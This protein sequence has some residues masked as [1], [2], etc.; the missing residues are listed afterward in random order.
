MSKFQVPSS[1]VV[2]CGNGRKL[3]TYSQGMKT[4]EY[5]TLLLTFFLSMY[6]VGTEIKKKYLNGP[7]IILHPTNCHFHFR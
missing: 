4:E 7:T 2:S 1:N 5:L 3:H 6:C